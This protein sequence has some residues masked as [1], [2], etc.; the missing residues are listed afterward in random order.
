M[1]SSAESLLEK[2][3]LDLVDVSS[4]AN[5]LTGVTSNFVGAADVGRCLLDDPANLQAMGYDKT[6]HELLHRL[7]RSEQ[8]TKYFPPSPLQAGRSNTSTPHIDNIRA[9]LFR[10]EALGRLLFLLVHFTT[11]SGRMTEL[12][13]QRLRKDAHEDSSLIVN[14]GHLAIITRQNKTGDRMI[15]RFPSPAVARLLLRY[16]L[17]VRPFEVILATFVHPSTAPLRSSYLWVDYKSRPLS[18]KVAYTWTEWASMEHLGGTTLGVRQY[19]QFWAAI[20]FR[21]LFFDSEDQLLFESEDEQRIIS[22]QMGHSH[23]THVQ[24]YGVS[25]D[26]HAVARTGEMAKYR[27]VAG[28]LHLLLEVESVRRSLL[29]L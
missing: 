6:S 2:L 28:R 13:T 18:E 21:Y 5:D 17:V 16:L 1:L 4:L 9:Y 26:V 22:D 25:A 11:V 8:R 23:K 24:V 20:L 12:V 15:V 29:F 14:A 10:A 27:Q 19:R 3:L 7:T